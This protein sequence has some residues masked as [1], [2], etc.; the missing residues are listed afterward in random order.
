[1]RVWQDW[2][3]GIDQG[4]EAAEWFTEYLS[5]EQKGAYRLVRMP[6]AGTRN[7]ELGNDKV[8]FADGY[9]FLLTSEA[10]LQ[11]LNSHLEVA[12]PMNRFRPNIVLRGGGAFIENDLR[13]FCINGIEFFPIKKDG[14]CPI[15]TID[16]TTGLA[17]KEPLATF[18]RLM[19]N[20]K[21]V[22]RD[23]NQVYFGM[24]LTHAGRG[25]IQ[26]GDRLE[27]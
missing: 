10:T 13:P 6:D 5:R 12:L 2:C 11:H 15:T 27:L 3:K 7:T 23:G 18:S 1:M 9:P 17:G 22:Y 21:Y 14:R 26:I 19:E 4:E 24:Y 8:G 16:Q 20:N 25:V